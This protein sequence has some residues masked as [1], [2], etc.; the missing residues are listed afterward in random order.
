LARD[1]AFAL[2][3]PEAL[4]RVHEVFGFVSGSSSHAQRLRTIAWVHQACGQMID[5]HTA[6]GVWVAQSLPDSPEPMI[7]LETA[8]PI[9][10]AATLQEALG[11]APT[12]PAA[13]EGIEDRPKRVQRMAHDVQQVKAYIEAHAA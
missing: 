11:Q 2:D 5:P 3:T 7:V 9:K 4:R 10:F 8:L 6:D 12:R 13:L 1:G